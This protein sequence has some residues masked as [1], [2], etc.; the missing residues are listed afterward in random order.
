M[1][2]S[3]TRIRLHFI[4]VEILG[5]IGDKASNLMHQFS[6]RTMYM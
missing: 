6:R 3:V 1:C 4:A 5:P 2:L